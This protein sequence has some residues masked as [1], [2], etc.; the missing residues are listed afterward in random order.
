MGR[1]FPAWQ[2]VQTAE[3]FD[4]LHFFKSLYNVNIPFLDVRSASL[5]IP[6]IIHFIWIG[7][8]PF[9]R[10][11]VENIRTWI[12]KHPDWIFKFWTDRD[13]PLPHKQMKM[14]KVQDFTFLKLRECY[15]KSDNYG[16]QSDILRY[17]ILF[18]E[19]GVYVDHDVKCLRSFESLNE[20]YDLY[21]GMELP[22]KTSLSSSILPTNS[23]IGSKANHPI[24]A[25]S[26]DWLYENWDR[27]D[28]AYPGKDRD[29]V[30]DRVSH[31]TF[32]VLGES[33]KKLAGKNG[34]RDIAFPTYYFNA[35]DDKLALFARHY[36]QGTWFENETVFEKLVRERL[37]KISKKVNKL[38]LFFGAFSFFSLVG[39]AFLFIKNRKPT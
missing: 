4:N 20:A 12:G 23:I 33:L 10:E 8:K 21:C 32:Q 18:Q 24:L 31:R 3:D 1:S 36:Y 39:F 13:R 11:S 37:M 19:G 34:N 2:Y 6:K 9:P 29:S 14:V 7:P 35:P 25:C 28:E 17:E 15:K 30:I 38:L 26:I 5:R 22:R 27:I 16:E